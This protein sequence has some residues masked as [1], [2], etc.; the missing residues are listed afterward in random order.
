MGE[1]E[2][3][4]VSELRPHEIQAIQAMQGRRRFSLDGA[5]KAIGAWKNQLVAREPANA[6]GNEA[7]TG[8]EA[9]GTSNNPP[10]RTLKGWFNTATTSTKTPNEIVAEVVRVLE[11]N[12]IEHERNGYIIT[13][14]LSADGKKTL[15]V[16]FEVCHIPRLSLYGLH[17]KRVLGD[18]WLYKKFC[19]DLVSQMKL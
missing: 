13:A 18:V 14:W 6:S 11:A 1:E 10:I 3:G 16:E 12:K 7:S 17:L 9:A 15:R 19:Q 8:G 5:F 2:E 4:E